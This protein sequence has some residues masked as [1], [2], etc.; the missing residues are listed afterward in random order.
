MQGHFT[1]RMTNTAYKELLK[2]CK[3]NKAALN[4]EICNGLNIPF[5]HAISY[6]IIDGQVTSTHIRSKHVDMLDEVM[7]WDN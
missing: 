6:D 4:I 1:Y 5:T 7:I 2:R 3:G